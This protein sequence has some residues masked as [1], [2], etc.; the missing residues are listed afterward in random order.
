[1]CKK[2]IYDHQFPQ[3]ATI[4]AAPELMSELMETVVDIKSD[5]LYICFQ[6]SH[7]KKVNHVN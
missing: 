5:M 1:M 3:T 6:P 2:D 4:N 7:N